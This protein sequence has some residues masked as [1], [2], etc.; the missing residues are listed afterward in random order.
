MDPDEC[1][2]WGMKANVRHGR[3]TRGSSRDTRDRRTRDRTLDSS[4]RTGGSP[5]QVTLA[6]RGALGERDFGWVEKGARSSDFVFR[7]T[8]S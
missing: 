8:E 2:H 7:S 3:H 1:E 4:R 6:G 5:R